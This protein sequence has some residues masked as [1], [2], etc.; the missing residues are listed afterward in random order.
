MALPGKAPMPWMV[1]ADP[2]PPRVLKWTSQ[3][4]HN[5]GT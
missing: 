3:F 1:P 2:E 5:D 4:V